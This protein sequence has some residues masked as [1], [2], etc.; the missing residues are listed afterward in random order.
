[1]DFGFAHEAKASKPMQPM[2]QEQQQLA[3]QKS[4]KPIAWQ[5]DD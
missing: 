2:S 1:M 3:Q 5:S 4:I